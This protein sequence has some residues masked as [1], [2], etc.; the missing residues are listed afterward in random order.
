LALAPKATTLPG[1][2]G[3]TVVGTVVEKGKDWLTIKPAKPAESP[4][5]LA[6]RSELQGYGLESESADSSTQRYLPQRIIGTTDEL[7]KDILRAITKTKVGDRVEVLW[8]RDGERRM[9]SL[10]PAGIS[11]HP[12]TA[13]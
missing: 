4:A 11:G 1:G 3:G 10:K 9:Y 5:Q 13:E 8:F 7:D 6:V 12:P 2:E